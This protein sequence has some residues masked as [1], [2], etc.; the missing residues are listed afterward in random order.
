MGNDLDNRTP[1]RARDV[2]R[3]WEAAGRERWFAKDDGFDRRFGEAFL[4]DHEAARAGELGSWEASPGGALAL[5]LLLDQF[6]RNVFRGTPRMYETDARAREVASAAVARGDDRRVPDA[7]A[8]FFYLPFGHSEL[9]ADQERSVE[10][11]R[12]LDAQTLEHAEHHRDIVRRFG[13]FPHRNAILGRASSAAER[14]YLERGG[15]QG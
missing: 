12:R 4:V 5:T 13:R 7:L 6:P 10:L 1:P 14:E 9:L 11:C 15:Y 8:Q 2:L 3:F